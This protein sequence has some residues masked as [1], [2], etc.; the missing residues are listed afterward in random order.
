MRT[1][2]SILL[3]TFTLVSCN[4][5]KRT[6]K[7][8]ARGQYDKAIDLAV[9][10]LQKGTTSKDTHEHIAILEEAFTK[11]NSEDI[12]KI[13]TY[14]RERSR[15]GI[16]EIYY[17]YL[18]LEERQ[19]KVRPLLPLTNPK[20][21]EIA[22]IKLDDYSKARIRAKQ[23]FVASLYDEA[24]EY[25]ARGRKEEYRQAHSVFR[26]I[27]ALEPNYKDV[28]EQ[29]EQTHF[30]GTDFVLVRHNNH[31][32]KIIPI[33][34]ENELLNFDTYDLD[35]YWTEYHSVQQ[36]QISY[37]YGIDLNFEQ[38]EIAPERIIERE[39]LKTKEIIIG[40]ENRVNRGGEIVRDSLGNPIK[41]DVYKEV[42]AN[43]RVTEQ[44][45]SVF[46]GGTVVFFDF[47]RNAALNQFP[48]KTEFIFENIYA[49]YT[50]DKRA[51]DDIELQW[52]KNRLVPFPTDEQM[53]L[54][55]GNDLKHQLRSILKENKLN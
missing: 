48:L 36:P 27:E 24:S 35:D 21:G 19:N 9:K 32:G 5:V 45:K 31:S 43:I 38:I 30:Y 17:T 14:R 28:R 44:Q 13:T 1:I 37:T 25:T 3:V 16:R 42:K 15:A 7:Y 39:H 55:A 11:A 4:S 52:T 10:K 49:T 40:Q 54:D 51:L 23:R 47:N 53:I 2:L 22:K 29:L 34:L 26:E 8:T 50:G 12:R 20:T 6:Q 18:Q 46:V 33:R 41:I